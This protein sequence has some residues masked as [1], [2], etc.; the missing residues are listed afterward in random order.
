MSFYTGYCML[1]GLLDLSKDLDVYEWPFAIR[2]ND[3]KA[4]NKTEPVGS[5]RNLVNSD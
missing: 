4:K 1:G 5:V 3:D 2:R